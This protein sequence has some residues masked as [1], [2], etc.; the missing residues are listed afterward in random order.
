MPM[1]NYWIAESAR[2][3]SEQG[4]IRHEKELTA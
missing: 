4:N 2:Q 1:L 3:E